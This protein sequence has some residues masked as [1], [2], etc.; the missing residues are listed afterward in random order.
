MLSAWEKEEVILLAGILMISEEIT[1]V[2]IVSLYIGHFL[3]R[4]SKPLTS[5]SISYVRFDK[6]MRINAGIIPSW[7]LSERN[8][9][10]LPSVPILGRLFDKGQLFDKGLTSTSTL[11]SRSQVKLTNA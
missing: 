2:C 9:N 1:S 11:K 6:Y 3:I 5:R 4:T 10:I 8:S 7:H